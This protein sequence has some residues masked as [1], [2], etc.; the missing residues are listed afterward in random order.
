MGGI[1]FRQKNLDG[2]QAR[3][4]ARGEFG[5]MRAFSHVCGQRVF[6]ALLRQAGEGGIGI[7][8]AS[9]GDVFQAAPR[10]GSLLYGYKIVYSAP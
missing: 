7:R 9:G 3:Q 4:K 5:R 6:R 1:G 2:F 8:G 10:G